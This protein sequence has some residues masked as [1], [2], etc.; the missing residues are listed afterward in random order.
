ML[1]VQRLAGILFEMQPGD[2]DLRVLPSA[3]SISILPSPTI[4][5]WYWLI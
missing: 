4:G 3:S 2:A 1:V 5:C